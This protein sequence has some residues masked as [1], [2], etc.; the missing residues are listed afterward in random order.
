MP[1][2]C[3]LWYRQRVEKKNRLVLGFDDNPCDSTDVRRIHDSF[4]F[5]RA[6]P[7][8][9]SKCRRA[10][11]QLLKFDKLV[12]KGESSVHNKLVDSGIA[13]T[14]LHYRFSFPVATWLAKKAPGTVSID[15]AEIDDCACLDDLL[16]QILQ[17]SED[18]YF[19][20]G[21]VSS[22][23][24]IALASAGFPGTDFDWL[25]AQIQ[26]KRMENIWSQLY[27]AAD[28]P[29]VWD[30][31]D[32]E[33]SKSRNVFPVAAVATRENGMRTRPRNAKKEIRRPLS[34]IVKLSRKDGARLID[35]AMASLA[36]RHR[37]TNHFNYAN[38]A[39]VYLADV[40]EGVSIAVFGLAPAYRYPLECTLGF[41]ILSNG[42]PVG[43]GGSSTLFLQVNTGINIFDEYRGSEASYLWVQVMRVYHALV[44]CTRYVVNPYQFGAGNDEALKSGAFW[45]YYHLGFRPVDP[46]VCKLAKNEVAKKRRRSGHRSDARTLRRLASCDMHLT[47]PGARKS[48]FFEEDWLATSSM[49]AT[50]ELATVAGRT[51]AESSRCVAR[52]VAR[53]LHVRSIK[54]WS[55]SERSGLQRIAPIV[56]ATKPA[57]WPS[58]AK[59]AM[60]KLLRAKGGAEEV[61]YA[62]LLGQH[63]MFR[64]E[65][66]AICRSADGG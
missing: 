42:V 57:A 11:E 38:P 49:L 37:E 60:R 63:Q 34:S 4:C 56:A 12:S 66:R 26:G 40:G 48:E 53:D 51:R 41:L 13:G 21:Y 61:V 31:G 58:D 46:K 23:E 59:A 47:L 28:L 9:L 50:Q 19:D 35:V 52:N 65:L 45:F 62:R 64:S 27:D 22:Q 33:L 32:S 54:S 39:E 29:L 8:T 10:Q 3:R 2:R 15:W 24:W 7:T 55:K 5:E 14:R 44:A 6:F 25:M 1:H 36:A 16:R 20:S 43:Y 17:S 30:I 18:D